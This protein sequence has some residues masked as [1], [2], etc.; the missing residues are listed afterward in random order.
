L[1][2]GLSGEMLADVLDQSEARKL[3]V[4]EKLLDR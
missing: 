4:D 2:T 1:N 3:V